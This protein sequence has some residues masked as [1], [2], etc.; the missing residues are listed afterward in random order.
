MNKQELKPITES[1]HKNKHTYTSRMKSSASAHAYDT[2]KSASAFFNS[3][4]LQLLR[5]GHP[6]TGTESHNV[7]VR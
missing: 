2:P 5:G 6:E 7:Y 3:M 1:T 4:E